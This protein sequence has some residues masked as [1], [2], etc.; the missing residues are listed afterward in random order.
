MAL[1]YLHAGVIRKDL[2]LL[3]TTEKNFNREGLVKFFCNFARS[4]EKTTNGQTSF[5]QVPIQHDEADFF[6]ID[7]ILKQKA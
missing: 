3:A 2:N 5:N 4:Y 1:F 6:N 7:Q